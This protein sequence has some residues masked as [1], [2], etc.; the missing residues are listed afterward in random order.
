MPRHSRVPP[1]LP[2]WF[3]AWD[4]LRLY[5]QGLVQ[6]GL[7]LTWLGRDFRIYR[8]AALELSAGRDP[9][10]AFS[11]WNGVD[12]H[13]AAPP[14]A[15]QLFAP[16]ALVPEG[17]GLWLFMAGTIVAVLFALRR[18]GLPWYWIAFPPVFEGLAA[19]NPQVLV[20]ALLVVG[21]PV[22][23]AA[24]AGLKLYAVVPT[25]ARREWRAVATII[26][27]LLLSV[28]LSP[29]VWAA[30]VGAYGDTV[31]RLARESQGGVSFAF[32]LD[33]GV[34]PGGAGI[35]LVGVVGLLVL[36]VATRDVSAA[37]WLVVPLL[38]PAAEYHYATF[39]LPIARRL[40]TWILAVPLVP[41]YLVG[42]I[43]LAY[44]IVARHPPMARE[45]PPVGLAE[46][47]RSLRDGR[48]RPP[49]P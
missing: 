49:G 29:T 13:Y 40:S 30:Y 6:R 11:T 31:A 16:A 47:L 17:V 5:Q 48:S 14:T 24:A 26:A 35:A 43:V 8:N 28:L 45:E 2:L 32:A 21:G 46:W 36:V 33:P 3:V 20:T 42:L 9:L 10:T 4:A 25:V 15:A 12:W 39:T 1:L 41:T 7:D 19:A 22:A 37:G 44:E 34:L 38:W 18:L 27:M 23:R